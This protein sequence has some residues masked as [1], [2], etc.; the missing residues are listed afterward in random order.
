MYRSIGFG[1]EPLIGLSVIERV[2]KRFWDLCNTNGLPNPARSIT[3]NGYLLNEDMYGTLMD[4]GI[5]SAQI[6]LDG[7]PEIHDLRR[8]LV[9]G[10]PTFDRI[11][12]N[13]LC[14]PEAFSLSVR[15]N[16]D[17]GNCQHIFELIEVLHNEGVIPRAS[18]Y[19]GM[20]ESFSEECRSSSGAFLSPQ[21]F[22][23]FKSDLNRKCESAGISWVCRETPRLTAVRTLYC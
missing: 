7:P 9:A 18:V 16:V 15:I 5:T 23:L 21:E 4:L 22:A 19:A 6:T 8:P 1:G 17:S 13:I 3:T 20:V 12:K 14:A 2:S 11:I 10:K